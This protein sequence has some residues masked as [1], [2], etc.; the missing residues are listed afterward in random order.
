MNTTH[1][2]LKAPFGWVGGKSKL[3]KD[4]VAAMPDH[5][6]YVEVF[7]GALN[8]L[9]AKPKPTG[10][11]QAE[12]VND[13][14]GD[15]INLHRM[16]Q[17]QPQTLSFYLNN[18]LI[19]RA[20][21][22]GI[23]KGFYRPRNKIERAAYYFYQLTQSFGSKGD[24]FAMSAK[25]RKPKNIYKSFKVWSERLKMVTIENMSFEE[26]IRT[27]DSEDAFFYCDP[28][29]VDTESYYKNTGGFGHAEHERLASVLAKAKGKFLVSYNDCQL[30][31][32]L[33]K[34]FTITKT[35]EIDYTLG[36]NVSG[37]KKS[38]QEV[39]ITNY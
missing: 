1:K 22:D 36:A 29:Y 31:R 19:S 20:I 38:V 39:F 16:I 27:Y 32:E 12:V 26:L 8:V 30:V 15:L 21:F 3:A 10:T 35:K 4:I 33:Y 28:P 25:S 34:E 17:T 2:Q 6:L 24:N 11:K 37:V 14:N 18:M 5:R 13:I 7:G 23:K 9:Y